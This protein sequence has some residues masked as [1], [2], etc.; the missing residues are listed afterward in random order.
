MIDWNIKPDLITFNSLMNVC[1]KS[2]NL[3]LCW[4]LF[5]KMSTTYRI[6][7]NHQT[8]QILFGSMFKQNNMMIF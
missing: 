2:N 5:N 7:P 8:H 3:S 6:F 4:D 1:D